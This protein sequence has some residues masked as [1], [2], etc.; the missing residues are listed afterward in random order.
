MFLTAQELRDLTGY[1]RQFDQRRW[2]GQ[3]HWAHETNASGRP[4]VLRS[5]AETKLGGHA[6]NQTFE[7]NFAA[8]RKAG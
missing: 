4:I 3:H 5:Y 7:P 2:L 1:Q 6:V 8:I